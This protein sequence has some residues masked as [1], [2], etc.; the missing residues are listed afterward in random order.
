MD[1]APAAAYLEEAPGGRI[2]AGLHLLIKAILCVRAN[3]AL[4]ILCWRLSMFVVIGNVH[5]RGTMLTT[6]MDLRWSPFLTS[7][8]PLTPTTTYAETEAAAASIVPGTTM[9]LGLDLVVCNLPLNAH[10]MLAM[11][12]RC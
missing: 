3:N 2:S 12:C 5:H 9:A 7:S 4:C 1:T 11:L 10:V 6:E 8:S